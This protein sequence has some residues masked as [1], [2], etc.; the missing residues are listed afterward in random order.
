MR[1]YIGPVQVISGFIFLIVIFQ[2]S[3]STA[4]EVAENYIFNGQYIN[5]T[6]KPLVVKEIEQLYKMR[7][8][9]N[10]TDD[11]GLPESVFWKSGVSYNSYVYDYELMSYFSEGVVKARNNKPQNIIV[12][13]DWQPEQIL[14]LK[15]LFAN[16]GTESIAA[17]GTVG[18]HSGINW[19]KYRELL[20]ALGYKHIPIVQGAGGD[21]YQNPSVP[22]QEMTS[23]LAQTLANSNPLLNSTLQDFL[24]THTQADNI[25]VFL[26]EPPLDIVQTLVNPKYAS[27]LSRIIMAANGPFKSDDNIDALTSSSDL[28]VANEILVTE[29]V[30]PL[31]I[32]DS[33][34]ITVSN[35]TSTESFTSMLQKQMPIW[36]AIKTPHIN[37]M[38]TLQKIM[39]DLNVSFDFTNFDSTSL[40]A[41]LETILAVGK[42]KKSLVTKS[43]KFKNSSQHNTS[44][45]TEVNKNILL[46]KL[47]QILLKNDDQ[48]PHD[49][50]CDTLLR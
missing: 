5:P 38:L 13:A 19:Y 44:H 7:F 45:V 8:E 3:V 1:K 6:I 34:N 10:T 22:K 37:G 50:T 20:N 18:A 32:F 23:E 4:N 48:P 21:I 33:A 9:R 36:D 15:M 25:I 14:A 35:S 17:L 26:V 40:L 43:E 47:Y 28:Q 41:A 49:K 30:A 31:L 39:R 16:L 12:I 24:T 27:S 46:R 29:S 42:N 11:I 2:T